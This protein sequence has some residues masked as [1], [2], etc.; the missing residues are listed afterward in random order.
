MD[1][2]RYYKQIFDITGKVALVTGATKGLGKMMAMNLAEAGCDVGLCSR[3]REEAE[4]AAREIAEATGRTVYGTAA[5]VCVKADIDRL[6]AEVEANVGPID[7]L[8]ASAG[9]NRRKEI[10]ELTEDDWDAIMDINVKGAFMTAKAVLP[11]M[12]ERGWGRI[13]FLGSM[14]SFISLKGRAAYSSSKSA[15]LGLTRTFALETARDG[16]CVNAICP[17]PFKT[18]MNIPVYTNEAVN[19]EFLEKLPIGRWGDPDEMRGLLLYVCSDACS[20]MTGSSLV[21]DGGWTAQ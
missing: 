18:P 15:L 17:G 10:P 1:N 4:A 11:G 8:L 5:D 6:I 2:A 13:V 20:F 9:I 19:R 14:L 3:N 12:R 21:I 16:I 7:I